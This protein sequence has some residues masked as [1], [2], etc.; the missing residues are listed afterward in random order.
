MNVGDI[1]SVSGCITKEKFIA[2]RTLVE[3]EKILGFH[4]GRLSGGIA[5]VVSLNC[6]ACSSSTS[7]HIHQMWR[8]TGIKPPLA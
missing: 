4:A 2:G 5:V 1:V 7:Q 8:H 3:I 6:R